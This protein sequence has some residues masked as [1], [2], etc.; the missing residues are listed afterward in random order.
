MMGIFG[1]AAAKAETESN[2]NREVLNEWR[3]AAAFNTSPEALD[4]HILKHARELLTDV[5]S[6]ELVDAAETAIARAAWSASMHNLLEIYDLHHE[7]HM[8]AKQQ[9]VRMQQKWENHIAGESAPEG[10]TRTAPPKAVWEILQR[11]DPEVARKP[12]VKKAEAPYLRYEYG[13]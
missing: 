5:P 2:E 9:I 7:I 11:P 6:G 3:K 8:T 10:E 4:E 12:E 1:R 13:S